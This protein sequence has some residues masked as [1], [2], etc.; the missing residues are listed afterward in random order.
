M[1]GKAV[2]A[3]WIPARI[4]RFPISGYFDGASHSVDHCTWSVTNRANGSK[5]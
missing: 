4:W 5:S 3:T 1:V 2:R